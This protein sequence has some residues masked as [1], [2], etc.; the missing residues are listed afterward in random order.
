MTLTNDVTVRQLFQYSACARAGRWFTPCHGAMPAPVNCS[1]QERQ[2]IRRQ[3][4][5][6]STGRCSMLWEESEMGLWRRFQAGI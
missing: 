4:K 2:R 6:E 3:R 5:A 1:S